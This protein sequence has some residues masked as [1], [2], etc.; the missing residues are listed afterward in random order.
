MPPLPPSPPPS[1]HSPPRT[2]SAPKLAVTYAI[3]AVLM[4]LAWLALAPLGAAIARYSAKAVG[5]SGGGGGKQPVVWF[6]LHRGLMAGA[7]L[8]TVAGATVSYSMVEEHHSYTHSVLG[9]AMLAGCVLQVCS[10]APH[11]ACRGAPLP[12]LTAWRCGRPLYRVRRRPTPPTRGALPSPCLPSPRPAGRGRRNPSRKGV[13]LP[14]GVAAGAPR[15]RARGLGRRPRHRDDGRLSVRRPPRRARAGGGR[16][17]EGAG[18]RDGRRVG[19]GLG[20]ARGARMV[21]PRVELGR[22][23]QGRD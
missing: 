17:R 9:T 2:Y 12:R 18:P 10:P 6:H 22:R 15:R 3:H 19:G 5:G 14:A 11:V 7:V 20:C 16:R 1:P 4:G 8:L 21:A 23:G 13:A